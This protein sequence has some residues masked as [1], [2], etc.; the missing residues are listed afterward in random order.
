MEME[1]DGAR[2]RPCQHDIAGLG[3]DA[4]GNMELERTATTTMWVEDDC[5]LVGRLRVD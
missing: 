3:M 1:R 4:I 5:V 2:E